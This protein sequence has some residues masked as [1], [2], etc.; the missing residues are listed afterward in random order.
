ME[1]N[2]IVVFD[3][4]L[5]LEYKDDQYRFYFTQID[6]ELFLDFL[7]DYEFKELIRF[8]F[9]II[10]GEPH[11][12]VNESEAVSYKDFNSIY[13]LVQKL[14]INEWF[15]IDNLDIFFKGFYFNCD[16]MGVY[17]AFDDI[18]KEELKLFL[19]KILNF[20]FNFNDEKKHNILEGLF[21]E[22]NSYISINQDGDITGVY[23]NFLS[24]CRSYSK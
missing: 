2:E 17:F 4:A 7:L 8:D 1:D 12:I 18:S 20:S 10:R 24:F 13:S 5:M 6:N 3:C 19:I 9:D 14:N 21:V 22:L 16:D 11:F 15:S 23:P